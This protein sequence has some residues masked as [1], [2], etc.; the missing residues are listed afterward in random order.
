MLAA[1]MTVGLCAQEKPAAHIDINQKTYAIYPKTM[2]R[3]PNV[4]SPVTADDGT[5]LIVACTKDGKYALVPVTV[6]DW[7]RQEVIYFETYRMRVDQEDFP[8][9]ARTGLHA[10]SEL[11]QIKSINRRP[12]SEITELAKPTRLSDSGF[13]AENEDLVGVLREDNHLVAKLGLR[14]P[15][16]ARPMIHL[17]NL[18]LQEQR[19][20]AGTWMGGPHSWVHFDH[21]LYNHKQ[22][23]YQASF[24]KGVQQ[25]PFNDGIEGVAHTRL[26]R[27]IDP[28]EEAYLSDR[29]RN[30]PP[31]KQRRLRERLS[32]VLT[33][34]MQPFYIARYGFY[35]G[36]TAWRTDPLAI[37]FIIGLRS[38]EELEA[39]F[40]GKLD[41]ELLK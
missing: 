26:W 15:Q 40:P 29:Y 34:E 14:H 39:A 5:E 19:A 18:I 33:G 41:E 13:L 16:L 8:T 38:L 17:W 9:L 20:A 1:G 2:E 22:I 32:S 11:A 36:H 35:E 31:E 23:H 30:L 4:S 24:T 12:V 25:S 27:E 6:A 10:D 28:K 3:P 7:T 37:A 21:F